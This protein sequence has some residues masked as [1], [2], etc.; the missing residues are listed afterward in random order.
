MENHKCPICNFQSINT[1]S[2]W[3]WKSHKSRRELPRSVPP[4]RK[5]NSWFARSLLSVVTACEFRCTKYGVEVTKINGEVRT[6]WNFMH[7]AFFHTWPCSSKVS[8][9]ERS[10]ARGVVLQHPVH[11]FQEWSACRLRDISAGSDG[12]SLLK[13]STRSQGVGYDMADSFR[14]ERSWVVC[15]SHLCS[16]SLAVPFVESC[17]TKA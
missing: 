13:E 5:S 2:F 16:W 17:H 14:W 4:P 7:F 1:E 9:A 10:V 12:V 3:L 6:F 15:L 11:V 8:V